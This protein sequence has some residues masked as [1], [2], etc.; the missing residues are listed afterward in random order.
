[1]K[2][3][4]APEWEDFHWFPNIFWDGIA[5]ILRTYSIKEL[6]ALVASLNNSDAFEWEIGKVKNGPMPIYY[7]LG[8]QKL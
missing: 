8:T 3:I 5:S 4:H 1:M 7:L 2:R 6:K